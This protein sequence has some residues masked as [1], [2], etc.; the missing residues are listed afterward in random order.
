MRGYFGIG[1][2]RISKS[3]NLGSLQRSAHA[4]DASFFFTVAANLKQREVRLSDTSAATEHLPVYH[5]PDTESLTLPRHCRLVG[6]ELT[7]DAID[8][9]SFQHPTA[10]AYILGPERGSLSPG[11]Q[12]R[13]DVIVK[14]PTRFCINVGLAGALVMYDR[15]RSL[16]RFPP[17]PASSL[18]RPDPLEAHVHGAQ[19]I[20]SKVKNPADSD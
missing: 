17:R 1:V 6:I 7:D 3:M 19:K 12:E 18:A 13:C 5:F 15:V 8:L 16:G 2:E 11:M 20:R 14:I 4:F 9:P 10:A